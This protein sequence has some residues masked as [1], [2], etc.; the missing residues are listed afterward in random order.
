M[1][2][3]AY[4]RECNKGH[5]ISS[6]GIL[7][8]R[9]LKNIHGNQIQ[10]LCNKCGMQNIKNV[11]QVFAVESKLPLLIC[12]IIG[13]S[14]IALGVIMENK[15][16]VSIFWTTAI[17]ATFLTAGFFSSLRTNARAFNKTF[18]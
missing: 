1:K 13:V 5:S 4:C 2:L 3:R 12:S 14:I 9:D 7:F 8:R 11:N 17:G 6:R 18:V 10:F 15:S 16:Q